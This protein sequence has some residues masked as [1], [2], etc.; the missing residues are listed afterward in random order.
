M[1]MRA[2]LA[3]LLLGGAIIGTRLLAEPAFDQ[4]Q[5]TPERGSPGDATRC[6]DVWEGRT[7]PRIVSARSATTLM[8]DARTTAPSPLPPCAH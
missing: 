6:N 2:L 8:V 4:A 3:A 5:R 7:Q 1:D